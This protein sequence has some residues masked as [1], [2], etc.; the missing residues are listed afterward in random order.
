MSLQEDLK[1][2][3]EMRSSGALSSKQCEAE[4]NRLLDACVDRIHNSYGMSGAASRTPRIIRGTITS[5]ELSEFRE[6]ATLLLDMQKVILTRSGKPIAVSD[7]DRLI[8][9]GTQSPKGFYPI[10]YVNESNGDNSVDDLRKIVP[11]VVAAGG[12]GL[13]A[14]LAVLGTTA[15]A[16]MTNPPII[17][18]S[19]IARTV[20]YAISI[21]AALGLA[22]L[23]LFGLFFGTH[24]HT[25]LQMIDCERS[26]EP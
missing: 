26:K 18:A 21:A 20:I 1:R 7:G 3:S 25:L 13:L 4:K 19:G 9:G 22:A 2:L 11:K 24:L 16:V 23:S 15:I 8:V 14:V 6:K 10:V 17:T 5:V 12:V